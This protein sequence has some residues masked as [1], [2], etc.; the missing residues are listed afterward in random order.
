M[1]LNSQAVQKNLNRLEPGLKAVLLFGP[2]E[3][4]IRAH[5][6][7]FARQIV[8]DP[9]DPFRIETLHSKSLQ[10][11]AGLL[12]QALNSFSLTPGRRLV[13]LDTPS[14]ALAGM[15]AQSLQEHR[16]DSFLILRAGDLPAS[17]KLRAMAEKSPI[18]GAIA[19]YPDTAKELA[20]Q[21]QRR[22]ADQGYP[23]DTE[24]AEAL[25]EASGG[26]RECARQELDKLILY[27][28]TPARRLTRADV[29]AVSAPV[30]NKGLDQV[31]RA[32][33]DGNQH[34]LVQGLQE[35]ASQGIQGIP[36]LYA[37]QNRLW[38]LEQAHALA[39]R[40]DK[41]NSSAQ[42]TN[43]LDM[44]ADKILGKMAWKEKPGFLAQARFWTPERLRKARAILH[45][46][47]ISYRHL[48]QANDI[49]VA[50]AL[51]GLRKML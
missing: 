24:A 26:E 40:L 10:D 33:L 4:L 35:L 3:A 43:A 51:L 15:I 46:A 38:Q 8:A 22:A 29:D 17:S 18:I 2:D 21:L 11:D 19:C 27:V 41:E 16:G 32:V 45:K 9:H 30:M 47:D 39:E 14:E 31:Q 50:Q 13:L 28:N 42:S 20:R 23:L 7:Q 1:K 49:M 37:V 25:V 48:T 5:A 12:D 36:L 6:E 44:A 34:A